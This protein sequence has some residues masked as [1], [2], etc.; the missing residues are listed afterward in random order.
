MEITKKRDSV[1]WRAAEHH[2]AEKNSGWYFI[3]G[4]V[5]LLLLIV[6]LFMKNFFF[7]V[8][9][10]FGAA[11]IMLFGSLEPRVYEFEVNEY[12]IR[13]DGKLHG[14]SEFS[15]FSL[16]KHG[17]SHEPRELVLHSK[18]KINP[19]LH[20]PMERR[21]IAPVHAILHSKLKETEFEE[22]FADIVADIIGF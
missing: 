8:L 19:F 16:R 1:T 17:H 11:L 9:I 6:A 15:G 3:I 20:L 18:K 22:S 13:I 21:T 10:L 5:A 4:G 14:Y 2:H 12:G 7:A